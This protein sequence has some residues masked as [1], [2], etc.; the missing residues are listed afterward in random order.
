[1]L[2]CND[3]PIPEGLDQERCEESGVTYADAE[4][5]AHMR[6][7]YEEMLDELADASARVTALKAA[8]TGLEQERDQLAERVNELAAQRN[9]DDEVLVEGSWFH[10]ADLPKILGNFMR[11]CDQWARE[12]KGSRVALDAAQVRITELEQQAGQLRRLVEDFTDPGDCRFDHNHSC[13]EH[14]F[15][16]LKQG[17]LCPHEESKQLLAQ[18]EE[19]TDRG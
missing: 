16:Y 3:V 14:G 17:D 4:L 5:I 12:A 7:T 6:N 1:M 9:P 2:A 11:S 19:V 8:N 15:F 10:P 18:W 13:Q